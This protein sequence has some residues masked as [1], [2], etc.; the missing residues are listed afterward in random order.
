MSLQLPKPPV[1]VTSTLILVALDGVWGAGEIAS[2]GLAVPVLSASIFV[3]CGVTVTFLQ[4]FIE[5]D[6]WGASVAKGLACGILAGVP[7]P[8]M[9]TGAGVGLLGW[10]GLRQLGGG[11]EKKE[12][13]R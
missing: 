12:E 7:F 6:G 9:G 5:G 1:G 10:A 3:L 4:R 13:S 2:V 8:V 11:E